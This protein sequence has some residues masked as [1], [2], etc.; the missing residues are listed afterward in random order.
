MRDR[1]L[2]SLRKIGRIRTCLLVFAGLCAIACAQAFAAP[3]RPSAVLTEFKKPK[4]K[5]PLPKLEFDLRVGY[6][7]WKHG[8]MIGVSTVTLQRQ[9]PPGW[10]A[11]FYSCDKR[12]NP[13]AVVA[14]LGISHRN[15]AIFAISEGDVELGDNIFVKFIPPEDERIPQAPNLK[16]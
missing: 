5:V 16:R 7:I 15:C 3:K 6:V 10:N 13:L 14:D 9:T 2:I 12:M 8:E 1:A 4:E 11:V